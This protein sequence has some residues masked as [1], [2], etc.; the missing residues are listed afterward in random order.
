M[1]DYAEDE[2]DEDNDDCEA[3][4]GNENSEENGKTCGN[5]D[6]EENKENGEENSNDNGEAD[7]EEDSESNHLFGF[8]TVKERDEENEKQI[9]LMKENYGHIFRSKGFLWFAG[10]DDQYAEWSQAGTIGQ[11]TCGG[12]WL[13]LLPEGEDFLPD[14]GIKSKEAMQADIQPGIIKDRRQEI[15][16]IGSDLN[17]E[18]ITKALDDCLLKEDENENVMEAKNGIDLVDIKKN[19]WK[20]GW[21]EKES[22]VNP[23]PTWPEAKE[24]IDEMLGIGPEEDEDSDEIPEKKIKN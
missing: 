17:K 2:A 22:E 23:L 14:Q 13:A 19:G 6:C 15:V 10:R 20:F 18:A 12:P 8:A 21:K 9:K 16:I 11:L 3:K 1:V 7:A 4:N 5:D 24:Q